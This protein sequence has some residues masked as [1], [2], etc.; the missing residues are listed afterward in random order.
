MAEPHGWTTRP[1]QRSVNEPLNDEVTNEAMMA[2]TAA[3]SRDLAKVIAHAHVPDG[4]ADP[5][6]I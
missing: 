5:G 6:L 1:E 2:V 4:V 3:R